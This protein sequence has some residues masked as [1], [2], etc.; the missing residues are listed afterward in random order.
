[1]SMTGLSPSPTTLH[2]ISPIRAPESRHGAARHAG[3][4]AA[5]ETPRKCILIIACA[6]IASTAWGK[7][8]TAQIDIA[9]DA[10]DAPIEITEPEVVDSFHIWNGPGLR[11]ANGKP[12]HLDPANQEGYFIN[13]PKGTAEPPDQALM[14]D[15]TFRLGE[16]DSD[17]RQWR[18]YPVTY[19]FRPGEAGGYIY[20]PDKGQDL[21]IQGVE[22]NW[23]YS[24]DAW[25]A[26][27]RPIIERGVRAA[28]E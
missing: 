19:A 28:K 8:P 18:K 22:G 20:L 24:S 5:N 17:P 2:R 25:E 11:D 3:S 15:V 1:M 9:S 6:L 4:I 13:W 23:F 10:M 14:F 12:T 16:R 21:I 27:I 26:L 7:E